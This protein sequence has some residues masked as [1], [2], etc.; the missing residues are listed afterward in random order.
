MGLFGGLKDKII[1]K[2]D[3]DYGD[4]R[5][6]ILGQENNLES[7][8]NSRFENKYGQPEIDENLKPF[9]PG[10]RH[11]DFAREPISLEPSRDSSYEVIDRLNF[12]ENQLSAIKSQTELI[13]E[14]LKNIESRLGLQRRW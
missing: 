4:V 2:K 3:N 1:H 14:R 13:N 11:S 7:Q 9:N 5:D 12:I 8:Y 6:R 10:E